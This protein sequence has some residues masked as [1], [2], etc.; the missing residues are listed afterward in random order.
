MIALGIDPAPSATGFIV[1]ESADKFPRVLF[2]DTAILT[3]MTGFERCSA[4]AGRMLDILKEFE[5][6]RVVIEGYGLNFKHPSS[7]IPLIEVG[8]ILR[9][10]LKQL[11]QD[12]LEPSPGELKKAV[13][14]KGTGQKAAMMLQV[15]KRWHYEAK[16]DHRADA[17]GLA[18]IGL[19]HGGRLR[20][21]TLSI[22]EVAS[23]LVLK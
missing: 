8:T 2:E 23:K 7:V 12:Y 16:D 21:T 22:A 13:L 17:Y 6:D 19:A 4:L 20:P 5:P 10:F 15:F 14:G 1:L 11:E 9:Y 18:A 3:K